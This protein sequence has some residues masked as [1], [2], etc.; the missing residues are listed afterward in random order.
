MEPSEQSFDEQPFF[1]MEGNLAGE[2]SGFISK[3]GGQLA[4]H[5]KKEELPGN[6]RPAVDF[7]MRLLVADIDLVIF[8]TAWGTQRIVQTACAAQGGER[9]I[10]AL[11]DATVVASGPLTAGVL[12]ELGIEPKAV[13][14]GASQW[15]NL[16]AM[17]DAKLALQYSTVAI[18]RTV[19]IHG[20]RG[21]LEARGV[22]VIDVP[23][24]GV[25]LKQRLDIPK[26]VVA[27][28]APFLRSTVFVFEI[29]QLLGLTNWLNLQFDLQPADLL[30]LV[31]DPH[32]EEIAEQTGFTVRS[33][34]GNE[35]VACW[36]TK[37]AM[38]IARF[39]W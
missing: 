35:D 27:D 14:N 16:L 12:L 9:L 28:S 24:L 17:M 5:I 39:L 34:V 2:I 31:T 22:R 20:I 23:T 30:V 8:L 29:D 11:R 10:N 26:V 32:L 7:G 4:K 25:D 13:G 38:E 36:S 15:R 37:E 21:G 18:E 19:S 3:F 33:V 6:S 1:V